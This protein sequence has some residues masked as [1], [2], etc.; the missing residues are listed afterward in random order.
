MGAGLADLI[1]DFV[2]Q[3][4][5]ASRTFRELRESP[6]SEL[7]NIIRSLPEFADSAGLSQLLRVIARD[8]RALALCTCPR[9][10]STAD[11]IRIARK[12]QA[13]EPSVDARMLRLLQP[14]SESTVTN[15]AH[16]ARVLE[17]VDVISDGMRTQTVLA[18]LLWH[19]DLRIRSKAALLIGRSQRNVS[20]LER[21]M[22]DPDPRVRANAVQALWGTRSIEA[23]EVFLEAA[24]DPNHRVAANSIV[25][26]HRAGD[27]RSIVLASLMARHNEEKFRAA[28]VWAMGET[29]DPRFL[30]TLVQTIGASDGLIRRNSLRATVAI[31]KR[32]EFLALQERLRISVRV[33]QAGVRVYVRSTSR[34]RVLRLPPTAFVA[35]HYDRIL[36]IVSVEAR[37][38]QQDGLAL[39]D[40]YDL[41]LKGESTATQIDVYA[42]NAM[43]QWA[44]NVP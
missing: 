23:C 44:L 7:E 41:I 21:Q 27:L 25:G 19:D 35:S 15:A 16:A 37:F 39:P 17:I 9:L 38:D 40:C 29:L 33:Q 42:A 22:R 2:H 1:D 32:C 10:L 8:S 11:A 14:S 24:G 4:A 13:V 30:P 31:R 34:D 5:V 28:A 6:E 26:L 12:M 43:G 20:W 18:Q 36:E 3:P